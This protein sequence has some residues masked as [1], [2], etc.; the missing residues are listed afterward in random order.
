M[1]G[2]TNPARVLLV[3][4]AGDY[5]EAYHRL[6]AGGPETYHAQRESVEAAA[7]FAK[8]FALYGVLC[9]TAAE[10]YDEV[11][12]NGVRAVGVAL[13]PQHADVTAVIRKVEDVRPTHLV[14]TTPQPDLFAWA[15]GRGIHLLPALADT[16]HAGTAGLS[17][18]R[19]LVR[20]WRHAR[21]TRRLARL[22]NDRRVRW[23]GN[24]NVSASRDLVRIGVD[25]RKVVPCDFPPQVRPGQ[26]AP[27]SLDPAKGVWEL[28][29]VGSV[30]PSKGVGDAVRA[31]AELRRR[32]RNIRLRVMGRGDTREFRRLA[33]DAVAA[34]AITFD[35]PRPH[36]EVV[37]AMRAA[38]LVLVPSRHEYPEG[39]P[40]TIY[41]TL[42]VRTPLVCSDHPAFRDRVGDGSAAVCVPERSPA[43]LADAA[44]RIL[45]DAELYR[46]MSEAT[47]AAWT[48]LVCPVTYEELIRR[49]VRGGPEDERFLAEHSLASGRYG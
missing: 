44:E 42:A 34:G 8:A 1:T 30:V 15:L 29:Y 3:Q 23:V 5:R 27:K 7:E 35:G 32:G 41:E 47:A 49:W 16:F 17:W 33:E 39:L 36:D 24:H 6:A 22:L 18:P 38:D 2:P 19:R 11:M 31:A 26:H 12:P 10:A 45:T 4:W 20:A 40:L 46:R 25:P 21:Y 43:A 14:V 13:D 37:A 9:M 28:L 48:R